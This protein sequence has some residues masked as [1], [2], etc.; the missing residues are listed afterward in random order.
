MLPFELVVL[1][2]QLGVV[3]ATAVGSL[4]V[5]GSAKN[6]GDQHAMRTE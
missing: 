2:T 4:L 6:V 1:L 3:P 5:A